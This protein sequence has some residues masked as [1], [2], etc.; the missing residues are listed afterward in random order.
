MDGR[1]SGSYLFAD[2]V[3]RQGYHGAGQLVSPRLLALARSVCVIF[4]VVAYVFDEVSV[5]HEC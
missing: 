1:Q 3:G 2:R 4:L 5:R